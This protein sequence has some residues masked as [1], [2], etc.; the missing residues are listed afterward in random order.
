M[1]DSVELY[2]FNSGDWEYEYSSM[3]RLQRPGD[4]YPSLCPFYLIDHPEATVL[5][6]TGVSHDLV[7]NPAEYGAYG[8]PH[9]EA[10]AADEIH[11]E[12]FRPASEQIRDVGVDPEDVDFVVMTHLHLDH[13]GDVDSFPEAEFLVQQDELAY[14]WWPA[15]PIQRKLYVEGDFGVL[16]SP[17]FD[18]TAIEGHHDLFG[19]GSVECVP[20]PGHTAGHQSV[21]VELDEAGTVVL[22]GD[23]AFT[24][25]AV[26]RDL[27]PPFAWDTEEALRSTRRLRDLVRRE[28]ADCYLAHDREHHEALPT[29]PE[30]LE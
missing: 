27:Q 18:V 15:D 29:P 16:R 1:G 11:T 20:T 10:F 30:S 9:F 5:V 22:G 23:V 19:D 25:E 13:A 2:A 28:D 26:E 8:A 24:D 21:V 17:E 4:S 6:D 12:E 14:A 7:E 3:M